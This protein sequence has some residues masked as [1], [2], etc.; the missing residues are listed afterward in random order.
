VYD[1]VEK[2]PSDKIFFLPDRLMG[3][4]LREEMRRRGVA[5]EIRLTDG[6]C[7][8][9]QD[10][11]PE[12]IRYLRVQYPGLQVV[13]HPECSPGVLGLSDFVGSTSQLLQYIKKSPAATFLLLTECGL[14]SRL[15]VELPR[16][17]FV[18]SCSLCR[19]MKANTLED[20]LRV[21]KKPEE[22]DRVSLDETVRLQARRCLQ[23]MFQYTG[24]AG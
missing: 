5:K 18:G 6:T 12:M 9:H 13:S 23:A 11:D 14:I 16:K 2:I 10:Y 7:Y 22:K 19:Y 17:V 15:Q 3:L 24:G 8:V 21:L 20:I 4:N 1:I